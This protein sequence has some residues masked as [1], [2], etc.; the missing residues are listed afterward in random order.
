[1][2]RYQKSWLRQVR[3]ALK[4]W[5]AGRSDTVMS[6]NEM[7]RLLRIA[8][9]RAIADAVVCTGETDINETWTDPWTP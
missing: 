3:A 8:V 4:D 6:G 9:D 7:A 1:M 5:D 2:R